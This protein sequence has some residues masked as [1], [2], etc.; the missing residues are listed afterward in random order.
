M[1]QA[2]LAFIVVLGLALRSYHFLS[3]PPVW[4]DEAAQIYNILNK[5]FSEIL[6]PLFYS[7]ACPPLF[8][9]LEKGLVLL[10]GDST[11]ALRL[12]PFLA[13]CLSLVVLVLL[14]GRI[15]PASAVLWLALL[16]GCSD[17]LVW[18]AC[19]AKPYA[20]DV[21][22]AT[23]V[24]AL[25][26][27]S[28]KASSPSSGKLRS[29]FIVSA[30]SSPF[31]VY[32]AFPACFLLG[33]FALTLLPEVSR[34]RS[35]VTWVFYAAFVMALASS[36]LLLYST[37]I[38][39]QRDDLIVSCWED[40]FPNWNKPWL[41]PALLLVK[42]TELAR[43]AA[44]PAGN[45][46]CILGAIGFVVLWR[47]G[48]RRLIGLLLWPIA[49]NAVAWL[50]GSYP[51]GALRVVVYA[52]PAV[53]LLVAAGIMPAMSWLNRRGRLA[54]LG[55]VA[56]LLV[57]VGQTLCVFVK[58]WTRLDSCAPTAYVLE[59]RHPDEPVVGTLWEQTYYCRGLGPLYRLLPP[60]PEPPSLPP[61]AILSAD[62]LAALDGVDSLWLL[63]SHDPKLQAGQVEQLSAGKPWQIA[64]RIAFRDVMVLR[65]R[66]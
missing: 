18:H 1:L 14:A 57:P 62:A 15:L 59:H 21:L 51:L 58:P 27:G 36:F 34:S 25:G 3:N 13:S 19:E 8:L 16:L 66:R 60:N 50:L 5:D 30:A 26:I 22:V 4:H 64:E 38:Q 7:E 39:A 52:A 10:F 29:L 37:A 45:V 44:E 11:H 41:V 20:V 49:L 6:G 23:V 43:Y 42:L 46:L 54:P 32:L 47:A 9:A 40:A 61:A 17:R 12:L 24:L 2:R 33:G 48:Q 56:V 35:R 55:L 63:C 31:L 28:D 65:L 53:L